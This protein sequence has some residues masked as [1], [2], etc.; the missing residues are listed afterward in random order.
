[1]R[2]SV[3]DIWRCWCRLRPQSIVHVVEFIRR[4][5]IAFSLLLRRS[6]AF[7]IQRR[8]RGE[9]RYVERRR[10]G[11]MRRCCSPAAS[12][13]AAASTAATKSVVPASLE[14]DRGRWTS[15]GGWS[16]QRDREAAG[17]SVGAVGVVVVE[18]TTGA[19]A[20]PS[21]RCRRA[22][23]GLVRD[24]LCPGKLN[25]DHRGSGVGA[26]AS[27]LGQFDRSND[28]D[29]HYERSTAVRLNA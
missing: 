5:L 23:K 13:D 18:R 3:T 10:R 21:L 1:M 17:T 9:V 19:R 27:A 22:V 8:P 25:F 29:R 28:F 11:R 4:H 12:A 6:S 14:P 2:T 15:T 26:S 20:G 24:R 7:A 16:T